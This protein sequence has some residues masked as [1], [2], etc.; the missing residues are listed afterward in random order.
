V[1]GTPEPVRIP[2]PDVALRSEPIVVLPLNGPVIDIHVRVIAYQRRIVREDGL[3]D[4]QLVFA[5]DCT[6][7]KVRSASVAE[8]G[9]MREEAGWLR[10]PRMREMNVRLGWNQ[11]DRE[12]QSIAE[13]AIRVRKSKE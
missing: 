10:E 8:L 2:A 1:L 12:T 9:E 13:S 11:P 5:E 7:Q 6:V 4:V 3:V